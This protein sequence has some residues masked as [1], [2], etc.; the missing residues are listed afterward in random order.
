MKVVCE[1]KGIRRNGVVMIELGII[2]QMM[3]MY[4]QEL[5]SRERK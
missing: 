4:L 3:M 2:T 1:G 5:V